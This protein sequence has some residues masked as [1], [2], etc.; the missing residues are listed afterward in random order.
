MLILFRLLKVSLADIQE[1]C[2]T[3]YRSEEFQCEAKYTYKVDGGVANIM[4]F[5]KQCWKTMA[6]GT[7]IG[8]IVGIILAAGALA[9]LIYK[10]KITMQDRAEYEKFRTEREHYSKLQNENP[11]YNSP[12]R[13]YSIPTG[14]EMETFHAKGE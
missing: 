14:F 3:R 1:E 5:E 4:I 7:T 12:I 11:L 10:I 8:I 2:L 13:Q 6:A 9:I